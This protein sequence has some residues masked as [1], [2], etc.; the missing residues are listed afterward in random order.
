MSATQP[1]NANKSPAH[2]SPARDA[3]APPAG[4]RVDGVALVR[5]GRLVQNALSLAMVAG[6]VTLLRGPNGSGKS[7]LL[8]TIAGR[9]PAAAGTIAV[10]YTH[11][12]LPTSG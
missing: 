10:S 9:L 12:T 1:D 2:K 7:T 8:R 3:G 5:G 4:L 6:E 11:L